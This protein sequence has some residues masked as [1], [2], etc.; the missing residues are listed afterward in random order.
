MYLKSLEIQGFKSFADKTKLEFGPGITC[1]VGPNGSGKSNV[2][3]AL[4]WVLGEQSIK[5]LRGSKLEDIIFN[6][7][8]KR[9]PLGMAAV[10]L[11]FDNSSGLLPLDFTEVTVSRRVYRSGESEFFI[12][13]APCRLRDIQELFNDTGLGREAFAIIGQG[14]VDAVLS[15][16]PEERRALFEEAAGIVRYRNRKGE[17]LRKLENTD[18][19]LERLQDL[20]YE[21][22][23]NLSPLKQEAE[24]LR[25]FERKKS[26][27]DEL[28]IGLTRIK[29]DELKEQQE[30]L[31]AEYSTIHDEIIVIKDK[32][33]ILANQL[34]GLEEAGKMLEQKEEENQ[35]KLLHTH[36]ELAKYENDEILYNERRSTTLERLKAIAKEIELNQNKLTNLR[37][38][39]EEEARKLK[40]LAAWNKER[41][42]NIDEQ[43]RFLHMSKEEL[44]EKQNKGSSF[45]NRL[46][47]LEQ[48]V[49]SLNN[50]KLEI[51]YGLKDIKQRD[52][53]LNQEKEAR[54]AKREKLLASIQ[55]RTDKLTHAK[56]QYEICTEKWDELSQKQSEIEALLTELEKERRQIQQTILSTQSRLKVLEEMKENLEGYH[57]GVRK[58]LQAPLF[59]KDHSLLGVVGELLD[60]PS[61]YEKAI[62]SSL[63]G[64]VQYLV[65]K[66]HQDAQRAIHWLKT[67]KAGRVTFLPINTLQPRSLAQR[68]LPLLGEPG[69]LGLGSQL[70]QVKDS[71]L[72]IVK[73]YLLGTVI[74]VEN[75]DRGSL[76]AK[77][78][79]YSVK[80]VTLEGDILFPG[81]SLTGGSQ[82]HNR[83]NFFGRTREIIKQKNRLADLNN[84]IDQK[85][86]IVQ[87]YLGKVNKLK[88]ELENLRSQLNDLQIQ[89]GT[90]E[91]ETGELRSQ[92]AEMEGFDIRE[93]WEENQLATEEQSLT[94]RMKRLDQEITSKEQEKGQLMQ[95]L[96]NNNAQE[97]ELLATIKKIEATLLKE[98]VNLASDLERQNNLENNL[99]SWEKERQDYSS[100][101]EA[102]KK[103]EKELAMRLDDAD[104]RLAETKEKII[105][106]TKMASD[107]AAVKEEIGGKKIKHL[108]DLDL[109]QRQTAELMEQ[110]KLKEKMKH[111][112]EMQKTR[113]EIEW[114]N[115]LLRLKDTHDLNWEDINGLAPLTLMPKDARIEIKEIKSKIASLGTINPNAIEDYQRLDERYKFL[116][117]QQED[118]LDGKKALIQ[119]IEEMEK[120]M[121]QRF[122]DTFNAVESAF[123]E[124]FSYLFNGGQAQLELT[125]QGNVLESGI[126]II[127]NLPGK[128]RQHL[129]L[130][131]GGERALTAAA[132]LFALLKVR[133]SPFCVLDE[134]E[135]NLDE[136]NVDRF[137]SYLREFTHKTQFILVSHR[138]GTMEAADILYGITM[139]ES[140]VSSVI[141][142][143]IAS[144]LEVS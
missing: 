25:I 52:I 55:L 59:K 62:E 19:N 82:Q 48:R 129:A 66:T 95:E 127:V 17:A 125:D 71:S 60:V 6:G 10:T 11:V 110:M 87:T 13:K 144:A 57:M 72:N 81:G 78:S 58:L 126:D 105:H 85:T 27:L 68:F 76:I 74:V 86:Q 124:I 113:V 53:R 70:I 131:S 3:D 128:Q 32:H 20:L 38:K 51:Q 84:A 56:S 79:G 83:V 134:M 104:L 64:A 1:I 120:I 116:V 130:L 45:K 40:E 143:K 65:T 123:Q 5:T 18:S 136:V 14:Q 67:E 16:R 33:Q 39:Y 107:L 94:E 34:Q 31:L 29:L 93:G 28:E 114:D 88:K 89:I 80:I 138:Q 135:A 49:V 15:S 117:E 44:L 91:M 140:G 102:L 139:E 112:L 54:Y 92:L 22:E 12:N 7:S 133:P 36:R 97:K 8:E 111:D 23:Q 47:D 35:Q 2:C 132:L 37:T 115:A 73:D 141:S 21:L 61:Q 100:S 46:F 99:S 122:K 9:K 106:F 142:V 103:E 96:E 109:I 90:L 26:K 43:E 75:L 98:K 42:K 4:R 50:S 63:G 77:K 30:K 69:V 41:Q 121:R 24:K 108:A 101:A 119:V 137:A 118:L